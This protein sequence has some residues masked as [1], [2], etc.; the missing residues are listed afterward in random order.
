M[1]E[2]PKIIKQF[3]FETDPEEDIWYLPYMNG[4]L[5]VWKNL[6]TPGYCLAHENSDG[7]TIIM[8]SNI[9]IITEHIRVLIRDERINQILGN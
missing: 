6:S 9:E 7:A 5:Q 3:G 8:R 1:N 4:Q 2:I